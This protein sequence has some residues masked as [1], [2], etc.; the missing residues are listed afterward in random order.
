M[1]V[2]IAILLA[3][4][5]AENPRGPV[6]GQ[7]SAKYGYVHIEMGNVSLPGGGDGKVMVDLRNGNG[8]G[9]AVNNGMEDR[10]IKKK[11]VYLGTFDLAALDG[12]VGN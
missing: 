11:P 12:P 9:F 3:M 4:S 8:W 1:L 7:S 10:P 5:C 2:V 6:E